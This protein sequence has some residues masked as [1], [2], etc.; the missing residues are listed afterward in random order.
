MK[1]ELFLIIDT[2]NDQ[3]KII[4]AN[5]EK[6]ID[7]FTWPCYH[8]LSE[9][10]LAKI[11]HLLKKH[12]LGPEDLS[13]LAAV[14][15]PGSYTGLR[16]SLATINALGLGLKIPLLGLEKI[17]DKQ[18]LIEQINQKIKKGNFSKILLPVYLGPPKITK[19]KRNL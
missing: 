7:F 10:L 19:P 6:I 13:C 16:I 12:H 1:R 8:H 17:A 15:G 14:L 5:Q 9:T 2:S 4:L 3:G 11:N 18:M